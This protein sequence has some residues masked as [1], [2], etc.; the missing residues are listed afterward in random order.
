MTGLLADVFN[1][2]MFSLQT[3]T[4]S[5]NEQPY[6]PDRISS[7]GLFSEAGISTTTLSIEKYGQTLQLIANR[8]RGAPPQPNVNDKRKAIPFIAPHLITNDMLR[9]DE[10]QNVR[11][12]GSNDALQS[13]ADKRDEKLLRMSTNLDVTLEYH[14]L[15][16][17]QGIVLDADGSTIFNLFSDFGVAQP[18]TVP[19]YFDAPFD[20]QSSS[21][22]V[23]ATVTQ[24]KRDI[25]AAVGGAGPRGY[26]ALCGDQ[27]FD[28]MSNHPEVRG[29]YLAQVQAAELR[30]GDPLE[31]FTFAGVLFE[32]YRG[33]GEVAIAEDEVQ[34]VP[35]G[36]P[37]LFITRFAPAD[38]FGAV[39]T[40]GLP[41]YT[42][43]NLD[44]TGQRHIE[45]EAQSNPV[46]LCTRPQVL[47]TGGYATGNVWN[48][49]ADVPAPE[50]QGA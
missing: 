37:D 38:Y 14:R 17:I 43:A 6:I 27:F 1:S 49:P 13:I 40:I 30:E 34:F 2:D 23:R 22:V 32:N 24:I 46:N 18:A 11:A 41:K 36:V 44:P 20:N 4:A 45:L 39:N 21:G 33:W 19:F 47:Y 10:I 15:G 35:L 26:W 5:I 3:L 31:A 12:F 16:A 9:A 25:R 28:K 8:P 42:L 50:N 7:M 29:T 48:I